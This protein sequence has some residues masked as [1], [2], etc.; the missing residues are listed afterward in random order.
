MHDTRVGCRIEG[1]VGYLDFPH[2]VTARVRAAAYQ[3]Y[4]K[5]A[6]A[7][8][9]AIGMNFT[10]SDYLNSAGIG[11]IISLVED[12]A[13]EGRQVFGFGLPSH[14][15]K[16]FGMVGLTERMTLVDSEEEVRAVLEG[17]HAADDSTKASG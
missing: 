7:H 1:R 6:S 17:G 15:R 16:L 5:L 13:E 10:G 12:A 4:R 14:Y 11:L 8:V 2:D 3:A 9:D